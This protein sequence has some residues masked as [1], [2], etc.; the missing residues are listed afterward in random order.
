MTEIST[1][2][3]ASPW[4][5][6]G[7]VAARH[8]RLRRVRGA[9]AR[10]G[11]RRGQPRATRSFARCKWCSPTATECAQIMPASTEARQVQRLSMST[12]SLMTRPARYEVEPSCTTPLSRGGVQFELRTLPPASNARAFLTASQPAIFARNRFR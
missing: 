7:A 10:D 6:P 8:R 3:P 5:P 1:G 11:G 2:S 4:L 9:P 12:V